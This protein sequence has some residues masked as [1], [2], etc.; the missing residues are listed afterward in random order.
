MKPRLEVYKA[1]S[2]QIREICAEHTR[3]IEPLS[4]TRRIWTSTNAAACRLELL[5][6]AK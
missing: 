6:C 5:F 4:W 1:A 2:Q 3:I